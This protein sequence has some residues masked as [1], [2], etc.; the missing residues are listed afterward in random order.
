MKYCSHCGAEV[1][2]EAVIC[3]HC[4][5]QIEGA[6]MPNTTNSKGNSKSIMHTIIK[7]LLIV[8]CVLSAFT[9]IPLCWKIPMTVM[10]HRKINN[11]EP[12]GTGFAICTMLFAELIS[13]ILMLCCNSQD[14]T[15]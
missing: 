13:G 14:E 4:G 6:K 12:F 7:I 5:C 2:D 11:N 8:D 1:K 15:N 9:I 3:V 10:A